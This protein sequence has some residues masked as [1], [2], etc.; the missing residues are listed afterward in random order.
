[1]QPEI[2]PFMRIVKAFEADQSARAEFGWVVL[3]MLL[4]AAVMIGFLT[5]RWISRGGLRRSVVGR[6]SVR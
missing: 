4:V 2:D 1:M 5:F 6:F 3:G